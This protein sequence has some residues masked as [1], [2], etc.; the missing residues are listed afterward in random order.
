MPTEY[1]GHERRTEYKKTRKLSCEFTAGTK[2]IDHKINL[3]GSPE[4]LCSI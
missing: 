1:T 3:Y 2:A 4:I